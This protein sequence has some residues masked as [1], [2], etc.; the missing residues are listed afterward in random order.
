MVANVYQH[1]IKVFHPYWSTYPE[2][3]RENEPLE[4]N[5]VIR[6]SFSSPNVD[7]PHLSYPQTFITKGYQFRKT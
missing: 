1:H 2:S 3:E 6:S 5:H 4:A 7:P